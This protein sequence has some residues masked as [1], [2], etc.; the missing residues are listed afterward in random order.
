MNIILDLPQDHFAAC[1]FLRQSLALSLIHEHA[2]FSGPSSDNSTA[3][4]TARINI[5]AL[6]AVRD[7]D[8]CTT[9]LR[10]TARIGS[11]DPVYAT[12]TKQLLVSISANLLF[13]GDVDIE[14]QDAAQEVLINLLSQGAA[15]DIKRTIFT[16]LK[17]V[18]LPPSVTTPLYSDKQLILQGALLNFRAQDDSPRDNQLTT[19]FE[20]WVAQVRYALQDSN[21]SRTL[22][23]SHRDPADSLLAIRY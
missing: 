2:L 8:A 3:D 14:V 1:S 21:V 20:Q 15:E 13:D 12:Q 16:D 7:P 9:A 11:I 19:D 22:S 18:H 17:Q 23:W 10:E 5:L 4:L 6:L